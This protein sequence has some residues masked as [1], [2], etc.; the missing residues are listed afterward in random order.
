MALQTFFQNYVNYNDVTKAITAIIVIIIFLLLRKIFADIILR[1]IRKFGNN[2]AI[3]LY[4]N[5]VESF[6]K[7]I[8]RL[9]IVLGIFIALEIFPESI[10]TIG[11]KAVAIKL[12]RI[13]VIIL[14]CQGLYNFSNYFFNI[15]GNISKKKGLDVDNKVL[16]F[17]TN[18]LKFIIGALATVLVISELGY[19]I[20][21][22]ITG[23]G[24]GG[25][26][27]ALAAQ[28]TASNIFGGLV[29]I[30]DK[31]FTIGDW[32]ETP[33][34]EGVVMDVTLRSTRIRTFADSVSIM[35]NSIL[36]KEAIVNWSRMGKRR[37]SFTIGIMYS[38]PKEKIENCINKIR[39]L[40]QT[41][42]EIHQQT[43]FVYLNSLSGTSIDIN[44]YFFTKTIVW[45]EYLDVKQDINL[46]ILSILEEEEVSFAL[47]N[48]NILIE[49]KDK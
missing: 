40:L 18:I 5:I 30:F 26:V 27:F 31:P 43:I 41:H 4:N 48:R 20:T 33:S 25:L 22:L 10:L 17:L 13:V 12:L 21:G 29:I 9:F 24:L 38:T 11:R 35:P 2:T 8:K 3:D 36:A 28:D 44:L 47:P 42:D 16:P 34:V 32:I 37:I 14:V 1:I 45:G 49:N 46:K 39:E 6:D 15:F 7:P 23:L 19:D